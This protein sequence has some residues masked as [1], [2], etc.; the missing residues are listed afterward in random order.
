M[1]R[2][3]NRRKVKV[4]FQN[5]ETGKINPCLL[6]TYIETGMILEFRRSGSWA[7]IGRDPIRGGN[8]RYQGVERRR[9]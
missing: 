9:H 7:R 8:G 6:N 1:W 3:A 4:K 5:G 2:L